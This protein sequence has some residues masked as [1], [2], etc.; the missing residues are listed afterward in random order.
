MLTIESQGLFGIAIL[1]SPFDMQRNWSQ[2][3]EWHH[4][5]KLFFSGLRAENK[6]ARELM[7][8]AGKMVIQVS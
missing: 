2:D 3:V 8:E 5:R 1:T 7:M 4:D 6:K